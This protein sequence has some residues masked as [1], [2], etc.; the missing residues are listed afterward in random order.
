MSD[1][2]G[3][4]KDRFSHNEANFA[5]FFIK[6]ILWVLIR[7]PRKILMSIHEI[8]FYEELTNVS[9]CYHQMSLVIKPDFAY[10]KTKTQISCAVTA[11]SCAVTAQLI[12]AFVFTK[13]KVQ[14]IF[15]LNPKFQASNHLLWVYSL[16]CVRPG[17][18]PGRRVFSQRGSNRIHTFS[19]LPNNNVA[20]MHRVDSDQPV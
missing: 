10:A 13:W 4:L 19:F 12:S 1:L 15:Y 6:A 2:L 20:F 14:S 11:L 16:V 18:K 5:Y 3:N 8:G 9:F 7:R 17:Q